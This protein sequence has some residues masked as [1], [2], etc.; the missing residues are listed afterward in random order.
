MDLELAGTIAVTTGP[1]GAIGRATATTLAG[2]GA[3]VI[4][5]S[6]STE[7]LIGLDGVA[8]IRL[9]LARR[10]AAGRFI[11]T[12]VEEHG[13]VDV[14]VNNL[15]PIRLRTAGF[16]T[17]ALAQEFGPRGVRVNVVSP[18]PT[19]EPGRPPVADLGPFATGRAP[20]PQEVAAVITVLASPRLG[21]VTGANHRVDGG[22]SRTI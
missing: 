12:V 22:L 9:D 11:G 19:A 6:R 4:A 16:L 14:L 8:P 3:H 17:Q 5:G 21:A 10:G 1:G 18:G 13:R 7:D 2:E 20:T 15:G